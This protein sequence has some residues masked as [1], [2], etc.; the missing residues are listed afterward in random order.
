MNRVTPKHTF[1]KPAFPNRVN[2]RSQQASTLPQFGSNALLRQSS[3]FNFNFNAWKQ[4]LPFIALASSVGL[5]ILNKITGGFRN[6]QWRWP[7]NPFAG[8]KKK[9]P[10]LERQDLPES[11]I[12]EQPLPRRPK[13][14]PPEPV[15]IQTLATE[16]EEEMESS[17]NSD[18]TIKGSPYSPHRFLNTP[19]KSPA[20]ESD[21]SEEDLSDSE[22]LSALTESNLQSLSNMRSLWLSPVLNGSRAS[23]RS[24]SPQSTASDHSFEMLDHDDWGHHVISLPNSPFNIGSPIVSRP[25]SPVLRHR[26]PP[27]TDY[28]AKL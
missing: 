5:I 1:A 3:T 17:V 27:Q 20:G 4:N 2:A 28:S 8:P 24:L 25:Q 21:L 22:M 26:Y 23:S 7:Q 16:A 10:D 9:E 13:T 12:E 11:D 18:D 6:F 14:P 15:K 19:P